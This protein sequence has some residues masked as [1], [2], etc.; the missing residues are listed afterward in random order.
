MISD[1]FTEDNVT[2]SAL[3]IVLYVF[4]DSKTSSFVRECLIPFRR[5]YISDIKLDRIEAKKKSLR[6]DIIN[7]R[8]P[9]SGDVMS[10]DFGEILTYYMATE[11]WSPDVD[12]KPM[13]WQ[14]KDDPKKASP[15]TDVVLFQL[16]NDVIHP[17][18]NDKLI[19]YEA[20][21]H[22]TPIAGT[23]KMHKQK[24]AITYKDGKDCCTFIDAI[25][26]AD[27]DRASRAAESIIY[28]KN[29]AEDTDD[30]EFLGVLNRFDKSFSVPYIAEHNA[31]AIV[32]SADLENQIGRMPV[33]L[34]VT[35]PGIKL[36]CM[37]INNLKQVYEDIYSL[38][39]NT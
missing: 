18:A 4:D 21:A 25:F 31:V 37:P 14:F 19:T 23:Y 22:A 12:Y 15:K 24:R 39:E 16:V 38:I 3:G 1:Y 28:L 13:K 29:K 6:K 2:Y 20:K 27:H 17:D 34:M 35:F 9:D 11:V 33:D 26:D 32:E 30:D 5:A 7:R 10:G 8:L 36:Y